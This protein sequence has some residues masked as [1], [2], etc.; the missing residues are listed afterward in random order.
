GLIAA[1]IGNGG[2]GSL[3]RSDFSKA[4]KAV[5]KKGL[6]PYEEVGS[7]KPLISKE[8][9]AGTITKTETLPALGIEH[10]TLSNGAHVYL[11]KT[12]FKEDEVIFRAS[13]PGGDSVVSA[14]KLQLVRNATGAVEAGGVGELDMVALQKKLAG[15]NV[16]LKAFIHKYE[17]GLSGESSAEDLE[18]LLQLTYLKFAAPRKDEKAFALYKK[19]QLE[20][21]KQANNDPE[22]RFRDTVTRTF[23]DGNP[24]TVPW[25]EA[26]VQLIELDASYE[27][28]EDRFK[29]A[30]DFAF[31]FTGNVEAE[32]LKPLVLRYLASL[33]DTGRREKVAVESWPSADK[34]REL[35]VKDGTQP[36]AT[37]V[38]MFKKSVSAELATPT[39]RLA[40]KLV[41][42]A[43]Q[44]RF[45]ELFREEMGATYGVSVR[46]RFDQRWTQA[47]MQVAFQC[48]PARADELR[49]AALAEVA[50]MTKE[51]VTAGHFAKA[52]ASQQKRNETDMLANWYWANRISSLRNE[53]RE[54]GDILTDKT[55]INALQLSDLSAAQASFSAVEN[56]ASAVLLPKK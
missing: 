9:I 8:P 24:R 36:R 3:K 7:D 11:K 43:M 46:T 41:G 15:R 1:V 32:T 23:N 31:Y 39:A 51:G 30:G 40:W 42:E 35:E 48:E 2:P 14:D 25:D 52:K 27:F 16:S 33:P 5:A 10:W 18:T 37:L 55:R 49:K 28:Y 53:E 21:L 50:R 20:L 12:A 6:S 29:D 44:M 45:L 19:E 34:P 54:L 4:L 47:V 38:F 56:V 17:E 13:S 22:T 26:A